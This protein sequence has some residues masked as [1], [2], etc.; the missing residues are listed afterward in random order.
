MEPNGKCS[1]DFL[2]V[3]DQNM[4]D[5]VL[6]LINS[7]RDQSGDDWVLRK[8]VWKEHLRAH[9]GL[10]K[11]HQ[12]LK[13]GGLVVSFDLV[14]RVCSTCTVFSMS[15]E[16]RR[17]LYWEQ[18]PFSSQPGHTIYAD[19]VGPTIAGRGGF[20]FL[21]CLVDSA[22]R[23]VAATCIRMPPSQAVIKGLEKWV[24][25]QGGFSLIVTDNAMY[26]DSDLLRKWCEDHGVK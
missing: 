8:I 12:T 1:Q 16:K 21:H 18:P 17:H 4:K 6:F 10:L 2:T 25:D 20:K 3:P 5:N 13:D 15:R 14:R 9:G 19:V 22:T 11:G 23:M 24:D 26:Y 7:V